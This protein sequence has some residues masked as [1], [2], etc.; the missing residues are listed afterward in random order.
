M[1]CVL[2]AIV[3][4]CLV[5]QNLAFE[6][7]NIFIFFFLFLICLLTCYF[8]FFVILLLL[9]TIIIIIINFC[10]SFSACGYGE[11]SFDGFFSKLRFSEA[12]YDY[13]NSFIA[14]EYI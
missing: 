3:I 1:V 11:L 2:W 4:N 6:Y 10:P 8:F 9:L 13:Q 12:S 14:E 5:G 7:V